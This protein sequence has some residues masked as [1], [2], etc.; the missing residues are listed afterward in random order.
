MDHLSWVLRQNN[1]GA[2]RQV[3]P[4]LSYCKYVSYVADAGS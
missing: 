3:K 1:D 2:D 4:Q